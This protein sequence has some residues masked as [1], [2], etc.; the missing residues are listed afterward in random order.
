MAFQKRLDF[1][2]LLTNIIVWL[3]CLMMI[4]PFI[5]MILSS[6]KPYAEI[7]KFPPTLLPQK[8]TF[9]YY[10]S[11]FSTIPLITYYFNSTYIAVVV[12]FAV[13]ITSSALGYAFAKFNFWGRDVL[14]LIILS[15]MMIPFP[16][17]MIPLYLE[18]SNFGWV[19]NHLALIVPSIYSAFG[20]FL[21]RQSMHS[22]PSELRDAARIDGC[23]EFRIFGSIV[24]PLVKPAI[25]SLTIL[26]FMGQW[27]NFVWPLIVLQTKTK[28][29]LPIGLSMFAQEYWV[30][31]GLVMAGTTLSVLPI[32]IVFFLMQKNFIEGIAMSGLKS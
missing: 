4:F 14:F 10:K 21:M 11:I 12:T 29:T 17:I 19:D 15:T 6:F 25:A 13:V 1:T 24:L 22:V 26:T 20:I 31:Y 9:Q 7:L 27:D 16:V 8:W 28:Y 32:L 3:G 2:S 5:W 30:E 23:S 18:I